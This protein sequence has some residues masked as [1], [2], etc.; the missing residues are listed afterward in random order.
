VVFPHEQ[1]HL[2]EMKLGYRVDNAR[3]QSRL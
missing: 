2:V 3:H 1:P